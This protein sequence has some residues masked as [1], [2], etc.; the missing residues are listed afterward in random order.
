MPTDEELMTAAGRGDMDAFEEL[1]RRHQQ[2]AVNIAYRFLGN[3]PEAEDLAQ[4]AFLNILERADSYRPTAQFTTFL[5]RVIANACMDYR[6]KKRPQP[7]AFLPDRESVSSDPG[8]RMAREER[9]EVVRKAIDGLPERQRMAL[10][11]QQYEDL[12]YL[13]IA[14]AMGC[15]RAAVESLL[16]RAR[17]N[18][19]DALEDFF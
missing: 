18:L 17:R 4:Q 9:V 11:L 15:S 3:Q 14:D 16:V 5:Y 10:V 12:S 13:E 6:R 2:R 19:R 8:R 7:R 1:V